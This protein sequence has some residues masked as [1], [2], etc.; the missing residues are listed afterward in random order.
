MME[1]AINEKQFKIDEQ[2]NEIE[3]L[4]KKLEMQSKFQQLKVDVDESADGLMR[5]YHQD[6]HGVRTHK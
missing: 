6:Q 5:V 2:T 4:Q 1:M 3:E